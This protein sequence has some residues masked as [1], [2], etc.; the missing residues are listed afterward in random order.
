MW[1]DNVRC[2]TKQARAHLHGVSTHGLIMWERTYLRRLIE[3][4]AADG[5]YAVHIDALWQANVEWLKKE[6]F[7]VLGDDD[8]GYDV[9]WGRS[10]EYLE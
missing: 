6:H 7:M 5:N 10:Y 9:S 2:I 4:E 1:R 3:L 8:V